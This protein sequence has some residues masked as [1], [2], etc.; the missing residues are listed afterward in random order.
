M[1]LDAVHEH[2][3][4]RLTRQVDQ[5]H[6]LVH[7]RPADQRAVGLEQRPEVEDPDV[8][9]AEPGYLGQILAGVRRVEVVPGVE[10]TVARRVVDAE[11][12]RRNGILP[13]SGLALSVSLA[14]VLREGSCSARMYQPP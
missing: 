3:E 4:A 2:I 13:R 5:V 10:P 8:V 14:L 12:E 1:A 9:Q 7:G 11:A 6:Q